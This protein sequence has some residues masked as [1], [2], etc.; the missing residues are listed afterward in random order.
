MVW[1]AAIADP[2]AAIGEGVGKN[3]P[4]ALVHVRGLRFGRGNRIIG[5]GRWRMIQKE[6]LQNSMLSYRHSLSLCN[7]FSFIFI[8]HNEKLPKEGEVE[9]AEAAMRIG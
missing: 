3:S 4:F 9:I 6:D 2:K 1:A 5:R 7:F 8:Y